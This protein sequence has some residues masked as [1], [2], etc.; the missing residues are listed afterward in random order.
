[1]T[2]DVS[3]LLKTTVLKSNAGGSVTKARVVLKPYGTLVKTI[4]ISPTLYNT[5]SKD[6][7]RFRIIY[8]LS[9][10]PPRIKVIR[11]SVKIRINFYSMP[12]LRTMY[13]YA[14]FSWIFSFGGDIVINRPEDVKKQ[15]QKRILMAMEKA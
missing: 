3:E 2:F 14:F 15:Y 6:Q 10:S 9:V 5:P 7:C 12:I 4:S 13:F 8:N 1:M 11:N